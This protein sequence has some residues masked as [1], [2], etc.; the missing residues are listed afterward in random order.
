MTQ[1]PDNIPEFDVNALLKE[2]A[3]SGWPID[4]S[5]LEEGYKLRN[6]N[7][8]LSADKSGESLLTDSLA[9]L[10]L[11][12]ELEQVFREFGDNLRES[13]LD[14]ALYLTRIIPSRSGEPLL[15]RVLASG[16]ESFE[17]SRS[18]V[19]MSGD[20]DPSKKLRA[21]ITGI[22]KP[23]PDLLSSRVYGIIDD[24]WRLWTPYSEPVADWVR[25]YHMKTLFVLPNA[26]VSEQDAWLARMHTA[27]KFFTFR[28]LHVAGIDWKSLLNHSSYN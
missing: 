5:K 28:Q 18:E 8:L 27:H 7:N 19:I 24:E 26:D 9:W 11:E 25:R 4:A 17:E 6:F 16:L 1:L 20:S 23:M 14:I 15:D 3:N 12:D 10:N 13:M 2:A 22:I 21:F